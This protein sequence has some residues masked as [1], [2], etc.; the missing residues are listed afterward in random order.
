MINDCWIDNC[1]IANMIVGYTMVTEG[2]M[3]SDT[4]API[5]C[6]NKIMTICL[7]VQKVEGGCPSYLEG[8]LTQEKK[9]IIESPF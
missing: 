5:P 7:I 3:S 2:L 9:R 1:M 6:G 8:K 4:H